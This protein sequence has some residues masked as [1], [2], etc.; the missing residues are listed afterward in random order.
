MNYR[1]DRSSLHELRDKATRAKNA[2]WPD[3]VFIHINKTAGSSIE[4][5]LG[6]RFEHKTAREKRDE[7]GVARWR[8]VFKFAFVRN[9][10]DKVISHYHFR[11]RTNQTGMGVGQISFPDWIRAAYRDRDPR[12]YD[13]PLM[14]APQADWLTDE[15]GDLIVDFIGRFETLREDFAALSKVLGT[16]PQLPHLKPSMHVDCRNY[17]DAETRHVIAEHF[18]TDCRMFGYTASP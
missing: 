2:Y 4:R 14:F 13:K 6:L 16:S 12:Y 9:P 7:L 1:F 10:W 5:A 3:Y 11:V 17:Y 18:R 8:K 15:S